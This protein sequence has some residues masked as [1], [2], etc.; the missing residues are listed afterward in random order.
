MQV[1]STSMEVDNSISSKST[2]SPT[3]P[4]A[5]NP[6]AAGLGRSP[7]QGLGVA[8]EVLVPTTAQSA[9]RQDSQHVVPPAETR[10]P[11]L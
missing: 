11:P 9:Q 6:G 3:P 7:Q 8:Q 10:R 4:P 5:R 1:T 2:R